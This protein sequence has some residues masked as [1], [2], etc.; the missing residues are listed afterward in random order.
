MLHLLCSNLLF[1]AV[2][3][4]LSVYLR[5]CTDL[6]CPRYFPDVLTWSTL[7][8]LLCERSLLLPCTCTGD[9]PDIGCRTLR[10]GDCDYGVC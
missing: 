7:G 1:D 3:C 4:L 10:F 6:F 9:T 5:A 2:R 8:R